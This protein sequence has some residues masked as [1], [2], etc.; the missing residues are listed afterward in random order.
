MTSYAEIKPNI[1]LATVPGWFV[2][3][4]TMS[5]VSNGYC[6]EVKN[7]HYEKRRD[8]RIVFYDSFGLKG[9]EVGQSG[10]GHFVNSSYPDAYETA[11]QLPNVTY[12]AVDYECDNKQRII[13]TYEVFPLSGNKAPAPG[14]ELLADYHSYITQVV[15]KQTLLRLVKKVLSYLIPFMLNNTIITLVLRFAFAPSARKKSGKNQRQ[16]QI[17]LNQARTRCSLM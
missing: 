12:S 7:D 17:S 15:P 5:D 16:V 1:P 9:F 2:D 11:L 4:P 3:S 10:N 6:I 8:E 14:S 13:T